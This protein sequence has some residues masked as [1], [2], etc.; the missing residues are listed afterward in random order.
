MFARLGPLAAANLAL[1]MVL[2]V[3]FRALMS[4][5]LVPTGP[6]AS[7]AV[8]AGLFAAGPDAVAMAIAAYLG[9][10]GAFAALALSKTLA[11][12]VFGARVVDRATN[13]DESWLLATVRSIAQRHGIGVPEVAVRASSRRS[14]VATGVSRDRMLLTLSSGLLSSCTRKDVESALS[15]EISHVA[16]GHL[17]TFALVQGGLNTLVVFFAAM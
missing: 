12:R 6:N 4:T 15:Q 9:F 2:G 7:R 13:D 8:Q 17:I 5:G 16:H 14:V 3:A 1:L 11:K 10:L